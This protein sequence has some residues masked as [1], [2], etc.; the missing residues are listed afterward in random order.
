MLLGGVFKRQLT[1]KLPIR[2]ECLQA[3]HHIRRQSTCFPNPPGS[4][5]LQLSIIKDHNVDAGWRKRE[6][7]VEERTDGEMDV[8]LNLSIRLERFLFELRMVDA[9]V[10]IFLAATEAAVLR[11][12]DSQKPRHHVILLSESTGSD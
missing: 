6:E 5:F 9:S 4:E 7:G 10:N 8:G 11:G 12:N 2:R 3:Q 1:V